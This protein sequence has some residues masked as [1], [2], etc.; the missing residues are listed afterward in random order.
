[1]YIKND[2]CFYTKNIF[3]NSNEDV[4]F[5]ILIS[6]VKLIAINDFHQIDNKTNEIYLGD[7]NINLLQ[8]G[9]KINSQRKSVI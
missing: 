4:F 5:E 8:N 1:M 7:F 3:S 2:L 6:K 9:W